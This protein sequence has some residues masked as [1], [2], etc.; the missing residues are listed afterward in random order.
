LHRIDALGIRLAA[1]E[2]GN[3]INYSA[4]NGDL[5][6]YREAGVPTPRS[7]FELQ[8]RSAFEHGLD[9]YVATARITREE[10]KASL[11]SRDARLVSAGLSDIG[12]EEADRRGMERLEPR[13]VIG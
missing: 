6:V 9:L 7:V 8:D 2:L 3:E 13:E 1:V 5:A 11:H 10:L 12:A 4:Y